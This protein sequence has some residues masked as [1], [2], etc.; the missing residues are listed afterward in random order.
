MASSFLKYDKSWGD[1]SSSAGEDDDATVVNKLSSQVRGFIEPSVWDGVAK[2]TYKNEEEMAADPMRPPLFAHMEEKD[3]A[4]GE[5]Y[6][7]SDMNW[8][9]AQPRH[10]ELTPDERRANKGTGLKN[11]REAIPLDPQ[12]MRYTNLP[13]LRQ[14]V[15]DN[16]SILHRKDTGI[17]AKDQRKVAKFIKRARALGLIPFDGGWEV[18]DSPTGGSVYLQEKGRR[19]EEDREIAKAEALAAGESI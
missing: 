2:R 19:L 5:S 3:M 1:E 15:S 13:F 7:S 16:G 17:S 8:M 10:L 6:S 4:S 14:F 12:D 9:E 18:M 11:R